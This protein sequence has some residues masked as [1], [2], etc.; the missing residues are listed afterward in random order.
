MKRNRTILDIFF[1]LFL[2]CLSVN[3]QD[4][5]TGFVVDAQ[6][7]VSI[8]FA[9]VAY[10]GHQ[11][12]A[13]SDANGCFVIGRH[14]GWH[15]TFS[16]VG[17]RPFI[18]TVDAN[19]SHKLSIQ[20]EPDA[21]QL[22]EVQVEVYRQRYRRKNNPAVDLMKKVVAAKEINRI[23]ANDYYSYNKYEKI[24]LAA[25]D[26]KPEQLNAEP[27]K[28]NTWLLDKIEASPHTGK[29]ILPLY[30]DETISQKIYRRKDQSAKTV[31]KGHSS[32][33]VNELFQTGDVLNVVVKDVFT[34]I[35]LYQN[36]IR[37]L[38]YPFVSPL[39]KEGIRFYRF[40]IED[41][42]M[43][44]SDR[45]VHLHFLPN[46][47]QDVGFRGE[48]FILDDSTYHLRRAQLAIPKKSRL[49]FVHGMQVTQEY[50]RLAN[51]QWVQTVD[52]MAIELSLASFVQS[53]SVTRTTRLTDHDFAPLPDSLFTTI[54]P[55]VTEA[56]AKRRDQAYWSKNRQVELTKSESEIAE[57]VK[58][59]ENIKGAKYLLFGLKALFENSIETGS[60]NYIDLC[61]V[62]TLLTHNFVDGWRVRLSAK[63][64]ANLNKHLFLSGYYAYGF[65]SR[66]LYYSLETTYS[67]NSKEYLPHEFPKR[68]ITVQ[69]TY[70]VGSPG[71]R[72][73]DTDKDN[74]MV[75]LKW[76]DD[77]KMMFYDRHRITFEYETYWG[78]KAT[79]G[80]KREES[81]AAGALSFRTLNQSCQDY[82]S[83]YRQR[84][85]GN[86]EFMKTTELSASLRYAPGETYINGKLSRR[87][88]NHE[89]PVF[90]IKHTVGLKNVFGGQYNYNCTEAYA[91]KRFWLSTWGK[92]DAS[93][94][95]AIQWNR[96]P[97]PLLCH[98]PANHSYIIEPETFSL[99]NTLE[100]M[101]D[102]Y[103][104]FMASWDLNGR[105]FSRI[106][107]LKRLKWREY[108]GFRMLWGSLSDKNNPNLAQNAGTARLMYFPAGSYVM[109]SSRPYTELVVGVHNIFRV[110]H[111]EYVRRLG[112]TQL[113]SSTK[114][115][116]RYVIS[117]SF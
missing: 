70:D 81:E 106:P 116:M 63:T 110:F 111:V 54:G 3:A 36:R 80:F 2:C 97:Y 61:P 112:Y 30:V 21:Q 53:I 20:L 87:V 8:P 113:P 43:V 42:L 62:N 7:G 67:L 31:I 56:D 77:H 89:A 107:L 32:N 101:N 57:L 66:K 100:F 15:L 33:G 19:T 49:N 51:G 4:S 91:Y 35:D 99:I 104:S 5:L 76:A 37:L 74:F 94:R 18:L 11:E 75:A 52:D 64:T 1:L 72:F 28:T 25:N 109:D 84:R 47:Q 65:G 27:F 83:D 102:R 85:R 90:G 86:G 24:T 115:G 92:I 22:D 10:K 48:L 55:E 41:T 78:M 38:Q 103:V 105:I 29:L 12:N 93:V 60:P 26:L 40:Y 59:V 95:G 88:V 117:L 73:L 114:W 82:L 58:N 50:G 17:Y 96:V 71:D 98:P 13:I 108:I 14:E 46:N 45:C 39:S 9:S 79:F 68:S 23:E 34:D 6:T 16:A 69:S 44:G